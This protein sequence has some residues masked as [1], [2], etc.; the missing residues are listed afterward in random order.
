M[1]FLQ[2]IYATVK[3]INVDHHSIKMLAITPPPYFAVICSSF[4]NNL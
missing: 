3:N 1:V 4:K 2:K